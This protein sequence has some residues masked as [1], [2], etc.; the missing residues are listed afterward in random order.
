[1]KF[2]FCQC[3]LRDVLLAKIF[4]INALNHVYCSLSDTVTGYITENQLPLTLVGASYRGVSV[5]DCIYNALQ[6]TNKL[7]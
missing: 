3:H 6:A 4:H 7:V 2:K 5:N 1:M